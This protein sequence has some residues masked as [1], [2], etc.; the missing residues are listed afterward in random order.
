MALECWIED[1]CKDEVLVFVPLNMCLSF[2][3]YIDV[4]RFD[5]VDV[6]IVGFYIC[7][8]KIGPWRM[9]LLLNF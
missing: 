4:V 8:M 5:C 9:L 6:F 7:H 2:V 3:K 1:A